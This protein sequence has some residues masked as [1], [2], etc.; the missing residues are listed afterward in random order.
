MKV[1]PDTQGYFFRDCLN[2]FSLSRGEKNGKPIFA[3]NVFLNQKIKDEK[4]YRNFYQNRIEKSKKE[5]SVKW[6]KK[7]MREKKFFQEEN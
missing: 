5:E 7:G 2:V 1:S 3:W 6:V 4:K